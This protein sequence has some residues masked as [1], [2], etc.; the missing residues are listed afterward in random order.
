MTANPE[1]GYIKFKYDWIPATLPDVDLSE[2]IFWRQKLYQAKLIGSYSN[3]I[4]FGNI[5]MR[6]KDNQFIISASATGNLAQLD[7][8]HF[9]LVDDFDLAKN[10]LSCVGNLP[11]SSESLSHA[12][13]YQTL[14][15]VNAIIHIHHK[16]LWDKHLNSLPTSSET[17]EYGTPALAFSLIDLIQKETTE[18]GII[19]MGGHEEGLMFYNGSFEKVGER[20]FSLVN[21]LNS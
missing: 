17:A 12:A 9:A 7:P 5:S 14:P 18:A 16:E 2:L 21:N 13:I 1:E 10:W 3:G 8:S 11:A 4:G 15:Q 6:Y 20:V 19:V